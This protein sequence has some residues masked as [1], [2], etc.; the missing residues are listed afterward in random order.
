MKTNFFLIFFLTFSH[1]CFCKD[2]LKL[3][4]A[5]Y[6]LET[7]KQVK[8][9]YAKDCHFFNDQT[10]IEFND[11]FLLKLNSKNEIEWKV[12]L[13]YHHQYQIDL[14]ENKLY[15]LS[16]T[17]HDVLNCKTRF[18]AISII[19]LKTGKIL[20]TVDLFLFAKELIPPRGTPVLIKSVFQKEVGQFQC[21]TTHVNS[22]FQLKEDFLSQLKVKKNPFKKGTW[23]VNLVGT[24]YIALFDKNFSKILWKFNKI[25]KYGLIHDLQIAPNNK[26]A[27]YVNQFQDKK[28]GMPKSGILFLNPFVLDFSKE[29]EEIIWLK[30]PDGYFLQSVSGGFDFDTSNTFYYSTFEKGH[31]DVRKMHL[32]GK[33]IPF[34]ISTPKE[35]DQSWFQQPRILKLDNI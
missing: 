26:I 10:H 21:E 25:S 32:N 16:T 28:D 33:I 31:Y 34:E 3:N 2:Y 29:K 1:C 14:I 35:K 22:L 27:I 13:L 20:K 17:A 30:S 23:L 8:R 7:K 12:D 15:V 4:C 11:S 6:D 5:L 24:H 18:D 19:D 9:I